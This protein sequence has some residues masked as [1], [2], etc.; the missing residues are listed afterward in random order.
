MLGINKP[1]T[2]REIKNENPGREIKFFSFVAVINMSYVAGKG[3]T[4]KKG[5]VESVRWPGKAASLSFL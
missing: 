2:R 4:R 1:F 3:G 5:R